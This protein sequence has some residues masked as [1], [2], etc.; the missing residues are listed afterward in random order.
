MQSTETK[1]EPFHEIMVLFVIRNAHAQPSSGARCLFVGRTYTQ[2][3]RIA[4]ALTRLREC[5]GSPEPSLVAYVIRTINLMSWLVCKL[6]THLV[7]RRMFSK[8]IQHETLDG[9]RIRRYMGTIK[10]LKARASAIT[11]CVGCVLLFILLFFICSTF[12][13]FY[14]PLG[15]RLDMPVCF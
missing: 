8:T 4:K 6:V 1:Y 15:R 9:G 5:A 12:R 2:C 3:V 7:M 14:L 13:S 11:S 10:Y